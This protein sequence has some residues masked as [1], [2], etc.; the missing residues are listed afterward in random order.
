MSRPNKP[1]PVNPA[2]MPLWHIGRPQ[3]AAPHHVRRPMTPLKNM[4]RKAIVAFGLIAWFGPSCLL[5]PQLVK[6]YVPSTTIVS[7]LPIIHGYA[8]EWLFART[9]DRFSWT[10]AVTMS[11]I[12]PIILVL[13]LLFTS[14][15]RAVISCG[16]VTSFA[17]TAAGYCLL[18]A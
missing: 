1:T 7:L 2:L 6:N 5:I 8:L 9:Y 12:L 16:S 18:I 13:V 14:R 4:S 10:W 3:R 17:L 11:I 15:R